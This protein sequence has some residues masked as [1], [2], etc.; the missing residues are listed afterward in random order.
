MALLNDN[1]E[2]ILNYLTKKLYP[3]I[4]EGIESI[5][6]E[7]AQFSKNEPKSVL[8]N[9]QIFLK[10]IPNWSKQIIE[11]EKRRIMVKIKNPELIE[12][13]IKS[14]LKLTLVQ[15]TGHSRKLIIKFIDLDEININKFIHGIYKSIARE[16][17]SNPFLFYDKLPPIELKKHQNMV[18]EIIKDKIKEVII[19]MLPWEE[20]TFRILESAEEDLSGLNNYISPGIKQTTQTTQPN[21]QN[22]INTQPNTQL[23]TPP[24]QQPLKPQNSQNPINALS[25]ITNLLGTPTSPTKQLNPQQGGYDNININSP[26]FINS[27]DLA[28]REKDILS[29]I[30]KATKKTE[31]NEKQEKH[32]NQDEHKLDKTLNNLEEFNK[33]KDIKEGEEV[34][35]EPVGDNI[36]EKEKTNKDFKDLKDKTQEKDGVREEKIINLG[37]K[38]K[39]ISNET[40]SIKNVIKSLDSDTSIS[41]IPESEDGFSGYADIFTNKHLSSEDK[42]KKLGKNKFFA[43]Y[44]KV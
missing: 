30:N 14:Y 28:S 5:Y 7:A 35:G 12:M 3:L 43:N 38:P 41:H 23:N 18:L 1:R 17:Y 16:L 42:T 27:D 34:D 20:I 29:I 22:T 33:N 13:L 15:L 36:N 6:Q 8:K 2:I 40:S 26:Q 19:D 44:L 9:F 4:Y 37:T 11:Q 24:I 32:T 21:I 10:K 39:P 31:N 25:G